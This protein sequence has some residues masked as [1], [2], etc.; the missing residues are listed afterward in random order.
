M[1][2]TLK[3]CSWVDIKKPY[4]I[5]YHDEEWGVPVHNDNKHFEILS[6]E[7]FQAG[8]SWDTILKKRES[9]RVAFKNFDPKII[10][11]LEDPYLEELMDNPNIVRHRNKIWSVRTNAR[12]F[13]EI[14]QKFQSFNTFIW[15]KIGGKQ[16]INT[17]QT[18]DQVPAKTDL[19][20]EI[21]K[22]L[23][24]HGMKFVGPVIV[25]SYLQ[26]SGLINDHTVNCFRHKEC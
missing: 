17:W 19:S 5:A 12:A 2:V 1:T 25:Y 11:T 7:G 8:L 26:A 18:A 13:L 16:I 22:C 15:S 3:R 20:T 24:G 14:Q 23:K 9:F 10:A 21:S 6:L 4:Y